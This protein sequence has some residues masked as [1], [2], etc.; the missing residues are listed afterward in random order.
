MSSFTGIELSVQVFFGFVGPLRILHGLNSI[1]LD[2]VGQ[3][4]KLEESW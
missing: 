2:S 4:G 1:G 3:F